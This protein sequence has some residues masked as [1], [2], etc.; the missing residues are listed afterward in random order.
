MSPLRQLVKL[1]SDQLI[2]IDEYQHVRT[3]LLKKLEQN[4]T[5]TDNDLEN[6]LNLKTVSSTS[7]EKN[8]YN[9]SDIIIVILGLSAAATLAYILYS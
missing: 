1:Y 3:H 7:N 9:L 4:G 8:E 5:I 2:S 6:F